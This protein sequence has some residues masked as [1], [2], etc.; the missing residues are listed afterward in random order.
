MAISFGTN[1]AIDLDLVKNPGNISLVGVRSFAEGII[2]GSRSK[3][4]SWPIPYVPC[5]K[6][7]RKTF[8]VSRSHTPHILEIT[9]RSL[10]LIAVGLYLAGTAYAVTYPVKLSSG[11]PR[12]LV[13][14]NNIPFLMVGDSPQSLIVNLS[15]TNAAFY[16]A[17]RAT[18][19]F[20]TL[21]VDAICT[22]YTFGP[23]QC[24]PVEWDIAVHEHHCR[25]LL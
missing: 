17:D 7:A 23:T 8:T 6:H 5:P 13:D 4:A 14:Q 21:L 11:N 20:N 19:G 1:R 18:N 10:S 2:P 12:I 22:T 25:R 24:Q 15:A 16:V 3:L 9:M